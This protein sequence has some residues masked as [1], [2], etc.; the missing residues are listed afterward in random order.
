MKHA[1]KLASILLALVM[2]LSMSVTAFAE[3]GDNPSDPA[4]STG[5]TITVEDAEGG[6][7]YSI[8]KMLDLV[9]NDDK[10]AF[11]YT[12]NSAWS[13]F[14][15]TDGDGAA[16]VTI[17]EQGYVTWKDGMD[18]AENMIAFGKAAAKYAAD[19]TLSSN[20]TAQTPSA[21]DD[22]TFSGLEAGYYLITSTNGTKVIVD[23]TPTNPNPSIKEK[24]ENPSI[25][26]QVQEDSKVNATGNGW[27][28]TN[29][30]E[31]GQNVNFKTV[32]SAKSGAKSY[33]VHGKMSRRSA[34][35]MIRVWFITAGTAETLLTA[36]GEGDASTPL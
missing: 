31:I 35:L 25:T 30:A 2:V 11:S 8:Y 29:D 27:G 18:T 26:K 13:G 5:N 1:K 33:V 16:Y 3:G 22:I 19:S 28:A 4:A 10:T 6:E 15:G 12:V 20:P 21:D 7:T 14:F 23:T 36:K 34:T 32:V 24:N 17:D 9:V